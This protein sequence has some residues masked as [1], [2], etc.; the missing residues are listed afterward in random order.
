[1]IANRCA[2]L[3]GKPIGSRELVHPN[4]HMNMGAIEQRCDPSAIH[5]SAAEQLKKLFSCP[6][7]KL[8]SALEAKTNEFWEIIKIG[9]TH[10]MDATR[11]G[12]VRNFP[13]MRS[14]SLMRERAEKSNRG[15]A[16]T[17]ARRHRG[18]YGFKST[19]RSSGK[20]MR[21]LSSGPAWLL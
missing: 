10:L 16:R 15:F 9:R 7:E 6:R 2:Q 21:H 1:V 20:V 5:I 4:D 13:V 3:A 11:C 12:S 18:R 19:C 17:R 8:H 14:K